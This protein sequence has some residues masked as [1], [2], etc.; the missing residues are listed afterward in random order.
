M[1]DTLQKGNESVLVLYP[2]NYNP[3]S[4]ELFW[5]EDLI[6]LSLSILSL[7]ILIIFIFKYNFNKSFH[8]FDF[9]NKYNLSIA[10]IL[11]LLII[12]IPLLTKNLVLENNAY[13]EFIQ[14]Q[15]SK[16]EMR[17][18]LSYLPVTVSNNIYYVKIYGQYFKLDTIENL[19]NGDLISIKG[20]YNSNNNIIK[21]LYLHKHNIFL[22]PVFSFIGIILLILIWIRYYPNTKTY[23]LGVINKYL[24]KG[25]I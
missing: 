7:L 13:F 25:G 22:K 8:S 10:V 1:L 3:V 11:F 21:V 20:N 4:F 19:K 9:S 17:V 16:N 5:Q 18:D 6:G 15:N 24:V 23:Y 2:I 12:T 14:N